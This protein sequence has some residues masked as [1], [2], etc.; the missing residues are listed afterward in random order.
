MRMRRTTVALPERRLTLEEFL[1]LPEEEPALEFEEGVVTQKVSPQGQ[2]SA[3]QTG[4]A[5][6]VDRLVEPGKRGR[7]FTELRVTFGRRSYVPDVVVYRTER[8][9]VDARGRIQNVF[10]VPPDVAVEIV[11]PGQSTNRLVRRCLWYVAHGVKAALLLDPS[12]ES[13]LLFRPDQMPRGL[14]EADEIDL[15]DVVP[16]LNLAVRAVFAAL[17]V[18]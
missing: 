14:G 12:D 7:A 15:S 3:L 18:R 6:L 17:L 8:I 10:T 4:L 11:S 2:H 9:P 16:G 1:A 5:K 13:I